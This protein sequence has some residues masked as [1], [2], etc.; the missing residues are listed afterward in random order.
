MFA[1]AVAAAMGVP[2]SVIFEGALAHFF[3]PP[4]PLWPPP[5]PPL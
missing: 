5:P 2:A 4:P 3:P 1:S